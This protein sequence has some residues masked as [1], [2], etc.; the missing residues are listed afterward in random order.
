MPK[1]TPSKAAPQK[2]SKGRSSNARPRRSKTTRSKAPRPAKES[3]ET[4]SKPRKTALRPFRGV[5]SPRR[6]LDPLGEMQEPR[7]W[8]W[9]DLLRARRQKLIQ[10]LDKTK[11]KNAPEDIRATDPYEDP[12]RNT[13]FTL[14]RYRFA[15]E[16]DLTNDELAYGEELNEEYWHL[17]SKGQLVVVTQRVRRTQSA[18]QPLDDPFEEQPKPP[19]QVNEKASSR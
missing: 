11:S 13:A 16:T 17:D 18:R 3:K 7:A 10:A 2:T 5:L 12:L 8:P 19:P 14:A 6:R 4:S 15:C 9:R 1:K